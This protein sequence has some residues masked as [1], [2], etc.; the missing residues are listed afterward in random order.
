MIQNNWLDLIK[1][2]KVVVEKQDAAKNA[3]TL[4][5][6]P[7]EKGFG[8]TLGTALRR[9]L[10]SSLQGTAVVGIRIDGVLHEFGSIP[11][12]KEDVIEL[13][14]NI[15][16]IV[17]KSPVD[18]PKRMSLKVKGP[19][20]ITAGQIE[21][22][23]DTE[24]INRDF[25]ICHLDSTANLNVEFF[26]E[27]GKGY[28]TAEEN[29]RPDQPIG[30]IPVDSIFSPVV[31]VS[32]NVEQARV[33]Q[34]TD[35]DKLV[36]AIKTNGALKPEDALAL[37]SRILIDQL[38]L[39]VNFEDPEV[40]KKEEEADELP[41]PKVLL[42]KVDELELSV[43]ANN[44]LKN[45]NIIYIGELV[46]KTENDMLKTPNFGRKS[47]NEI[48]E[49]LGLMGLYLG[50]EIQGWPP[51]NIEELSKRFENPYR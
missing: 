44:C 7:L 36:M 5:A 19:G 29:K 50:M 49:Q 2:E 40:V 16:N 34:K 12:V 26:V 38:G 13:I 31:N 51:E 48:K 47:L 4:I 8:L 42:K 43:R 11:G 1:P 6:E 23:S 24:I 37:S 27:N 35:Y 20:A 22:S 45:D 10:L 41:F 14:L 32:S 25:V 21:A 28:R 9:V 30:Y 3:A 39:F 17:L 46:Q 15:K 18:H 33:G